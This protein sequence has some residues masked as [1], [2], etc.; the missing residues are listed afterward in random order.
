M[1]SVLISIQPYYV[2]LIIARLMG[3]N[4]PQEK[5]V[6]VRKGFPKDP[7]WNKTVHIYCG[8]NRKS[9]NRIPAKYQPLMEKF[10][11]KVIGEFL[12]DE[13]TTLNYDTEWGVEPPQEGYFLVDPYSENVLSDFYPCLTNKELID[14]GKKKPLYGWH[15]S[16]LVIYDKPR[17]LGE[18]WRPCPD[19]S[20]EKILDCV[21]GIKSCK[22]KTEEL[23]F[24]CTAQI[25][26]PPQSWCYLMG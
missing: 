2:F 18:F 1:K 12:C 13:I 10:L 20:T 14:Y 5:T 26:S 15:I 6:E 21:A 25:T 9:F 11:G 16:E 8:K 24:Q 4:I 7:T 23:P 17:E 22:Y 3:W 19:N